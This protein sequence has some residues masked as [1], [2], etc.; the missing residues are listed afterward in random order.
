MYDYG[1]HSKSRSGNLA[2]FLGHIFGLMTAN[3]PQKLQEQDK[4]E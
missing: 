2:A 1:M 3:K 4:N